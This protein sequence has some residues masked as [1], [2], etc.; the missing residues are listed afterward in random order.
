MVWSHH[1]ENPVGILSPLTSLSIWTAAWWMFVRGENVS[2]SCS[3]SPPAS[4]AMSISLQLMSIFLEREIFKCPV[5]LL[6]NTIFIAKFLL[7]LDDKR[8]LTDHLI[9]NHIKGN[10]LGRG[11]ERKLTGTPCCLPFP[12]LAVI[13][14]RLIKSYRTLTLREQ[15]LVREILIRKVPHNLFT[16]SYLHETY[17]NISN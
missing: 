14:W 7:L 4:P 13:R 15:H 11:A 12:L 9:P 16:M 10:L 5:V 6:S 3:V 2:S 8:N 1:Q 17:Q